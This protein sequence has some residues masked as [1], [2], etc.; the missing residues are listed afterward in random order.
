MSDINRYLAVLNMSPEIYSSL[1]DGQLSRHL[2]AYRLKREQCVH[3]RDFFKG[4]NDD[5]SDY[6]SA[7]I[8]D[9]DNKIEAIEKLIVL[10]SRES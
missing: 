10:E 3:Y 7:E 1:H 2:Y 4:S 5:E 6:Y 8:V 9:I